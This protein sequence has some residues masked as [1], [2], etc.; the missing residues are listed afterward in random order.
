MPMLLEPLCK[1][2]LPLREFAL[3]LLHHS[4]NPFFPPLSLLL[5]P[6]PSLSLPQ[7]TLPTHFSSPLPPQYF[8]I[9]ILFIYTIHKLST[10]RLNQC[11]HNSLSSPRFNLLRVARHYFL[12]FLF[13]HLILSLSFLCLKSLQF[14]LL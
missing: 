7:L 13:S 6:H 9:C 12:W 10:D 2:S 11:L 4:L 1:E 3:P 14:C 5:L 8:H